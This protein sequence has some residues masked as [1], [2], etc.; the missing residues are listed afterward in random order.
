M[1]DKQL[2]ILLYVYDSLL[3]QKDA[4]I[5]WRDARAERAHSAARCEQKKLV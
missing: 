1:N 5:G 4:L 2:M 3:R